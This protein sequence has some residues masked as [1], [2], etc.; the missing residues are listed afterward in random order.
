ML[1]LQN[2]SQADLTIIKRGI[3]SMDLD[4]RFGAVEQ[5][6]QKH[7][8]EADRNVQRQHEEDEMKQQREKVLNSLFYHGL[9]E[10]RSNVKEAAP[11]TLDW[12]FGRPDLEETTWSNF[13]FWL[14]GKDSIYWICGKPGSGKSTLM[15]HIEDDERTKSALQDWSLDRKLHILSF[16]FWRSG[17]RFQ[18]SIVGL[19]QSLLFQVCQ[20][21]PSVI[22]PLLQNFSIDV[23]RTACF[24]IFT[25][26]LDEYTGN[27][28]E[29]LDLVLM[30]Q[31]M[32]NV[33][34]CVSSRPEVQLAR[35][36]GSFD[37]LRL[38]DLN[39][40]DIHQFVTQKLDAIELR[41]RIR[42]RLVR[43]IV[44]RA[45]GVFL[46]ATL[47]TQAVVR[48]AIAGDDEWV[49]M[50]R[51]SLAPLALN[52]LFT[53][54]IRKVD[55]MHKDSLL[56]YLQSMK[57]YQE[58]ERLENPTLEAPTLKSIC[59]LTAARI[60]EE[61]MS[62][63]SFEQ[64][65]HKTE[66]QIQAQ[67]AGLLE[68]TDDKT[69]Q[70]RSGLPLGS[71]HDW[72]S[73]SN[74]FKQY[75][76][77]GQG[78]EVNPSSN[79]MSSKTSVAIRRECHRHEPY[80]TILQYEHRGMN[81]VHRSASEF[82][83]DSDVPALFDQT[84]VDVNEVRKR[85]LQGALKYLAIAP[86][87]L[88]RNHQS[89]LTW[90]EER[91]NEVTS[92]LSRVYDDNPTAASEIL[93]ELYSL[94]SQLSLKEF[95]VYR[96]QRRYPLPHD[97]QTVTVAFWECC[98]EAF[99]WNYILSR[100]DMLLE[101]PAGDDFLAPLMSRCID[102]FAAKEP[103]EP[104]LTTLLNI[105]STKYRSGERLMHS[106]ERH[107]QFCVSDEVVGFSDQL[108]G[109]STTT[110]LHQTDAEVEFD[111]LNA[112]TIAKACFAWAVRASFPSVDADRNYIFSSLEKL[113][114]PADVYFGIDVGAVR[115]HLQMSPRLWWIFVQCT[116]SEARYDRLVQELAE[117]IEVRR[118]SLRIVCQMP[119]KD[120]VQPTALVLGGAFEVSRLVIIEPRPA[121]QAK[122]ITLLF[123]RTETDGVQVTITPLRTEFLAPRCGRLEELNNCCEMIIDDIWANEQ[124]LD[125]TQ[126][127]YAL[128]S[129]RKYVAHI[130]VQDGDYF[131]PSGLLH[132][133]G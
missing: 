23:N 29:L 97:R 89:E 73:G 86:S 70:R 51:V 83:F 76:G 124:G 39:Y 117:H 17:P 118:R 57:F 115:W 3:T 100:T 1:R 120:F 98:V 80:P 103:L 69:R 96:L 112:K 33:K 99:L 15:A 72:F 61:I 46:W 5:N 105:I 42:E 130:L 55:E 32:D 12:I 108:C 63:E 9:D 106:E 74:R 126:Q 81:W 13:D 122:L 93:D 53:E 6:M 110:S 107:L 28:D 71:E 116:R 30:F 16:F 49:L 125:G 68:I 38:Q 21:E 50:K 62:Y 121:S 79:M 59:V 92:F 123:Q 64:L 10:R 20:A 27:Y 37:Q 54:M 26:G 111:L 8:E 91:M 95:G 132:E 84:R 58:L 2:D 67:S 78:R 24:C 4:K 127:L 82:I 94:V 19:L 34:C 65:C 47:V 90:T 109:I 101:D 45:E 60:D 44:Y 14:R 66:I 75:H 85:I 77:E 56:F 43:Q 40:N 41:R 114:E 36:L 102:S 22:R 31:H 104:I 7:F 87:C 48:G 25:D 52:D 18:N 113:L 88:P 11:G 119:V 131:D 133:P 129:I 35:K 128:A